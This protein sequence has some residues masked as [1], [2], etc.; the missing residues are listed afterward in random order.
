MSNQ[1]NNPPPP[2]NYVVNA[3]SLNTFKNLLDKLWESED[4]L[5]LISTYSKQHQHEKQDTSLHLTN[6]ETTPYE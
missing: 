3:L 6:E 5:Y 4:V 2:P 1:W